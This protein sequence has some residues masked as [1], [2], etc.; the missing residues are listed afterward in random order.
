GAPP[1]FPGVAQ[2]LGQRA[3]VD[4]VGRVVAG[5]AGDEQGPDVGLRA[6]FERFHQKVLVVFGV[7]APGH[8]HLASVVHALDALGLGLGLGQRRK[9]HASQDRDDGDDH[10]ELD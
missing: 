7:E 10:Q 6:T 9:Q 5:A 2:V 1:D 8:H 4:G 3:L